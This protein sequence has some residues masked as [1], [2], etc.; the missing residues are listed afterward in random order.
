MTG[1]WNSQVKSPIGA[2]HMS[3]VLTNFGRFLGRLVGVFFRGSV[4]GL[5]FSVSRVVFF[6][7]AD[8]IALCT[9]SAERYHSACLTAWVHTPQS[10]GSYISEQLE[11][12][13]ADGARTQADEQT[14]TPYS[15]RPEEKKPK[16]QQKKRNQ[17]PKYHTLFITFAYEQIQHHCLIEVKLC[18]SSLHNFRLPLNNVPT[19][20]QHGC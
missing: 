16:K 6:L 8:H 5:V 10:N 14:A 15:K 9:M 3:A 17:I 18:Y 11:G 2:H 7:K 1:D 20:L 4:A 12:D 19:H 13:A